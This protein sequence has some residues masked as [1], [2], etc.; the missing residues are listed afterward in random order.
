MKKLAQDICDILYDYHDYNG[1]KFVPEAVLQ[2]VSQFDEGDQ[3]FILKEFLHLLKQGI[4]L[5]EKKAKELL[6]LRLKE[7]AAFFKLNKLRDFLNNA[8]FIQLQ[9]DNKS[10]WFL[11]KLLDDVLHENFG[12]RL[13]DCGK[14]SKTYTVYLDDILATGGTVFNDTKKWLLIKDPS[15]ETN[16]E[17]VIKKEKF[18]IVNCFCMH[19]WAKENMEWRLKFEFKDDNIRGKI[20]YGY[21]YLIE[22]HPSKLGQ[23]FNFTY[24]DKNQPKSVIDYIE[25][26]SGIGKRGNYAM[27]NSQYALRNIGKPSNESF[28][29]SAENRKRLEDIFL[30][31]GIEILN[32]VKNLHDNH[33]PLGAIHPSYQTLGLGTL[34]FTWRNISN[35]TPIVFWWDNNGWIPLF[36]LVNRGSG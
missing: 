30:L 4:Y 8:E 11:L 20:I 14:Q 18:F 31:K 3:E 27:K 9:P 22:N 15:G 26:L 25:K 19:T 10:Q 28:Y 34:Y 35:T 29:S 12:I 33:R 13:S 1:F 36:K 23:K 21:D 7:L 24:P 16:F 5:N 2:W 32:R 17:K 6:L